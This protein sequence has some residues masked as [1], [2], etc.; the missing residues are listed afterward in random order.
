MKYPRSTE[1]VICN[2]P[3]CITLFRSITVFCGIDSVLR[4]VGSIPQN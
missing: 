4:N 3:P 2:I 1:Y